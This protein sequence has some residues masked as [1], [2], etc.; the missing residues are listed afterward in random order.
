MQIGWATLQTRG[1]PTKGVG[2]SFDSFAYD[3]HRVFKW[4][5]GSEAYGESWEIGD[6]IG[7][8]LNFANREISFS[9]NG[10]S[11]G[12]AFKNVP[13]GEASFYL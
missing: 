13:I 11:L 1:L 10:K 4:N 7:C 3:G 2:D 9:R 12:I 8:Y 5:G 6:I